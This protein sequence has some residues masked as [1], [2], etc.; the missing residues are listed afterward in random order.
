MMYNSQYRR[1]AGQEMS[2]TKQSLHTSCAEDYDV[3]LNKLFYKYMRPW[4]N[5]LSI[6]YRV[7]GG[8]KMWY[9]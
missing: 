8:G 1:T 7:G 5:F 3:Y 4:V 9:V 2:K 6:C